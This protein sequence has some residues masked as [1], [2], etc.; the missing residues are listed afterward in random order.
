MPYTTI[1]AIK[2]E[3]TLLEELESWAKKDEKII[4]EAM[5]R[6][7]RQSLKRIVDRVENG[8]DFYLKKVKEETH[9]VYKV[10]DRK[11]LEEEYPALK[12][13]AEQYDIIE[14]LVDSTPD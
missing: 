8:L 5:Y 14:K 6:T 2:D 9:L 10:S 3:I 1:D 13:A 7:S 4:A 12:K 11:T